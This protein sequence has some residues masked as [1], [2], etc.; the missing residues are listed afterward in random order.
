MAKIPNFKFRGI[1]RI[2][3][4]KSDADFNVT[5]YGLSILKKYMPLVLQQ[6][7]LNRRKIDYLHNVALGEQDIN[8]KKRL[9]NKDAKNNNIISENH[10]F[11][12]TN[13]K[14]AFVTSE[15]RDYAHKSDS[16]CKDMIFLDRYFTDIDFYAKDKNI[17]EWIYQTGIGCSYQCH[18]TDIIKK[19]VKN[20]LEYYRYLTKNEG[21]DIETEAPFEFND[22]DPRDNFVVYSS[23]R[24]NEPLFCVSLVETERENATPSFSGYD[25]KIYIETRY[26]RFIAK[27]S[28]NFNGFDNLTFEMAKA[29]HSMPMVE[30]SI[31]NARLGIVELNRDLFN[32]LNTLVSNVLDM[33]VDGANIIMVF[34]NTDIDQKTIDA[35]NAKGALILNDNPENKN[36]SEAKL[37]TVTIKID[38]AGLNSFYEERLTQAYDIAGVPL[39]S[40]QVTS[41]GD[42]GQAR[43]LGGGWN[44]AYTVI[45]NDITTLLKG[46]YAVL[47]LALQI[48]KDIPGCPVKNI[49]ASQIDIKYHINQSDNLLTKAQAI[50][51]LYGVNMPKEEI[52][53]V[54]GLFS[55]ICAVSQKW[56]K[57]DK[58][59]KEKLAKQ[60]SI[61]ADVT[62]KK[63]GDTGG[64]N[65]VDTKNDGKDKD[66]PTKDKQGNSSQE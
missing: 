29:F 34:K 18:R 22:L 32:C 51:T 19:D 60:K 36:N 17:K 55:D 46:D 14:V 59:A 44:N 45:K 48:C 63:V 12:Q 2:T 27:C 62:D 6:H 42:T 43:L 8:G 38:F 30:H 39:A 65:N 16:N 52:L 9:Y 21:F 24:G 53:K 54:S 7:Q 57:E 58:E 37:E 1:Q 66:V 47:K 61:E 31:N 13:F 50:S 11:R 5:D 23:I 25:Y 35:M 56:D 3:V 20:K 49:T 10:A 40:G 15:K 33:V 64:D 26:A 28:S 41:G 4:P